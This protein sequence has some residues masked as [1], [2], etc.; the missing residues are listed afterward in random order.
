MATHLL[1][2]L[3][4]PRR[5][6]H[7]CKRS[8]TFPSSAALTTNH[9]ALPGAVNLAYLIEHIALHPGDSFTP[10]PSGQGVGTLFLPIS[11]PWLKLSEAS[12]YLH[13]VSPQTA[14]PIHDAVL[15]DPGKMLTDR[16]LGALAGAVQY[17]RLA[18]G[19]AHTI[20]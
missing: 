1:S 6:I 11:A 14:L 17:R 7:S 15:S 12:D 20:G 3:I 18:P 8:P 9:P 10:P 16:A 5:S 19:E 13:Q 4:E 2:S